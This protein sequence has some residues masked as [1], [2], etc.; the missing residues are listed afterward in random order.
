MTCRDQ[1]LLKR[2]ES[3]AWT[4]YNYL[5]HSLSMDEDDLKQCWAMACEASILL[6]EHL[7][8]CERCGGGLR[9]A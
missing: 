2:E 5:K 6:E 9:A 3:N 4:A 1:Q 8:S 7:K